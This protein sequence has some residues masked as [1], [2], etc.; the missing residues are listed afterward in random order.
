MT[1]TAVDILLRYLTQSSVSSLKKEMIDIDEP[2]ANEI[3]YDTLE[4]F[5]SLIYFSFDTV[6]TNKLD[7]VLGKFQEILNKI[8]KG[9]DPLDM[10]RIKSIIEKKFMTSLI[11]MENTAHETMAPHL[12]KD[13]LFGRSEAD[14]R[15]C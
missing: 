11:E 1:F 5:N 9:E 13:A 2:F 12:V 8:S 15:V 10:V 7:K 6:P 4:T 3:S 14:V